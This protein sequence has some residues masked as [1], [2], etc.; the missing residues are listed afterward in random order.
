MVRES[1]K[2]KKL[3]I[4]VDRIYKKLTLVSSGMSVLYMGCVV[5]KG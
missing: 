3:N 1:L 4:F 5:S 2:K